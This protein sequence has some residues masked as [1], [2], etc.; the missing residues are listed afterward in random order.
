MRLTVTPHA[1]VYAIDNFDAFRLVPPLPSYGS[2]REFE[3]PDYEPFI[4]CWNCTG[5]TVAGGGVIDGQGAAWWAAFRSRSISHT[6]PRLLQFRWCDDVVVHNVTLR[7]SPF[8]TLH[9]VYSRGIRAT[10]LT[11][12]APAD[13]GMSAPNTDGIDPDSSQDVLISDCDISTGDDA[14]AIKSGWDQFGRQVGIPT[15]N[16]LIKDSIFHGPPRAAAGAPFPCCNSLSI[17]SE[18]SG[19]VRNATVVNVTLA[20]T[21][22]ALYIKSARGRGGY[23]TDVTYSDIRVLGTNIAIKVADDYRA[24]EVHPNQTAIPVIDNIVFKGIQGSGVDAVM[25]AAG[26]PDGIVTRV[27]LEDS[28]FRMSALPSAALP[29]Y[30]CSNVEG[31]W[32]E[33]QPTPCEALRP[34]PP[35][36]LITSA[37]LKTGAVNVV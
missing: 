3:G 23:V 36:D 9:F 18:M 34:S 26:L 1:V 19:G 8:W 24:A 25:L 37:V 7:N 35:L 31:S 6:R 29:A 5:V 33:V 14:I 22:R 11:I 15:Q 10:H 30:N 13:T 21:P 32:R 2:G 27:R 16:V 28:T 12:R 4:G 20:N 17:G